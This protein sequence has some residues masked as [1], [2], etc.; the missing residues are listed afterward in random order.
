ML[1]DKVPEVKRKEYK[2]NLKKS[3]ND[4]ADR[5]L[6]VSGLSGS[7][8]PGATLQQPLER[9]AISQVGRNL[10][11][12]GRIGSRLPGVTL[13]QLRLGAATS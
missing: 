3:E 2:S 13:Q 9:A 5:V 4:N 6:A 8:L 11:V 10:V 7:H 12:S 1:D